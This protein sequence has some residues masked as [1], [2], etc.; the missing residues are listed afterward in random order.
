MD[1]SPLER[2]PSL[3]FNDNLS[4]LRFFREQ[5]EALQLAPAGDISRFLDSVIQGLSHWEPRDV[6]LG[7]QIHEDDSVKE[8]QAVI[9]RG[10]VE[11]RKRPGNIYSVWKQTIPPL[12]KWI[13]S[14]E[15]AESQ[16][17]TPALL[18]PAPDDVSTGVLK[19]PKPNTGKRVQLIEPPYQ[20]G[21]QAG[22]SAYK[23]WNELTSYEKEQARV[24][25]VQSGDI[26]LTSTPTD[27]VVEEW[28]DTKLHYDTKDPHDLSNPSSPE[29]HTQVPDLSDSDLADD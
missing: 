12:N 11:V 6:D 28:H 1:R 21:H 17:A 10:E 15:E 14:I 22:G 2:E 20:S 27:S 7:R 26:S 23:T 29:G 5:P 16:P 4:S 13:K 3:D 25:L 19:E 18:A 9:E 8:V 24:Q